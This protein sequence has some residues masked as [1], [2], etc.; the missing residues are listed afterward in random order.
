MEHKMYVLIFSII[1][2]ETFLIRRRTERDMIKNVYLSSCKVSFILVKF[3]WNFNILV[4]FSTN[5]QIS[6]FMKTVQWEPNCSAHKKGQRDGRT[7]R[8]DKA[9]SRFSQFCER[10][11]KQFTGADC[12]K[13]C[14]TKVTKIGLLFL[15]K[16][17]PF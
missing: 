5:T 16:Q 4:R 15:E 17:Q 12:V 7:G 2:S 8:H 10:A 9:K 11:S 6:N 13:K 3:Y 1:L 14:I